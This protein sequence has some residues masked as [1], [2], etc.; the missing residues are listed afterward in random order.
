MGDRMVI[1]F[2]TTQDAPTIYLYTQWGGESRYED[3]QKIVA[4]TRPRWDDPHY[5]TRI[6]I[7]QVVADQ[8]NQELGYGVS[9]N[10]F[11]YPDYDDV[12]V[13][14]WDEKV[15]K[16]YSASTHEEIECSEPFKVL[17][18]DTVLALTDIAHLHLLV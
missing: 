7:S 15:V 13:I 12:P 8:W 6:A 1:G 11:C 2:K 4:A 16:I 18:F 17:E 10:E 14:V 5:A 3:V 9:C